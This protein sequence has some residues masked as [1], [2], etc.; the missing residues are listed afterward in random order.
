MG[1]FGS[2]EATHHLQ[3]F[4][5]KQLELCNRLRHEI[6]NQQGDVWVSLIPLLYAVT[7]SSDTLIML[8]QK[9][10]LRDC[11]V[12]GRTIFETIVNALYICTQGDKAARK[13]KRHAYQKAYRDLER[14]L[15]INTEKISIR[16]T[17]KDNLPKDPELNFA[18]EEFT[19]KAGREITSWTP[20]NVKE[21]IEL[22]SSKYGNKVSRQ[23]QFGLLS[24]YRHSSEIAHGTLFGALFA[25]GMTSPGTPK[26]SE[27]LAQYQRGQLSMILLMLGLS[28]SAII[29]V[30]EKELGQIEFST[31][32]EQAIEILKGEPWLK[33]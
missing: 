12:I 22:I 6:T 32:S 1:S 17:G 14:D 33:D 25:L 13:A 28:I 2:V 27:E 19:S 8:S 26:T 11:F 30:I 18:I 15:Q 9:G 3:V 21:R 5:A 20:E 7:D 16:W 4:F 31:E 24:I 10:N 29:L 23:L